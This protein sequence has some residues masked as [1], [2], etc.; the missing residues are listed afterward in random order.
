[1]ARLF[2]FAVL[3]VVVV[4]KDAT[5]NFE[6]ST[7]KSCAITFD[8]TLSTDCTMGAGFA[9][10]SLRNDFNTLRSDVDQIKARVDKLEDRVAVRDSCNDYPA[11]SSDGKYTINAA[12]PFEVDCVF[13][14]G[15]GW[16]A[17][18]FK[19]TQGSYKGQDW[20]VAGGYHADN[21]WWKCKDDMGKAYSFISDS[22]KGG[23]TGGDKIAAK[24]VKSFDAL[25]KFGTHNSNTKERTKLQ[26][27]QPSTGKTYTDAQMDHLRKHTNRIDDSTPMV[28]IDADADN[29]NAQKGTYGHEAAIFARDGSKF[30]CTPC[31]GGE[32]GGGCSGDNNCGNMHNGQTG[33]TY[34]W[35]SSKS[36]QK[37]GDHQVKDCTGYTGPLTGAYAKYIL[38]DKAE[39]H[40][41]TGGGAAFGYST[42]VFLTSS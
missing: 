25:S 10:N 5:L 29:S 35:Y 32:C 19:A 40:V 7:G 34:R 31:R 33:A 14:G 1:M 38:P 27:Y 26:Y 24:H 2:G 42:K 4:S 8:G 9:D 16:T 20:I 37:A 22:D 12:S 17:L 23:S 39:I 36:M 41:N 28:C 13:K 18:S 11:S 21:P 15:R 30:F 3:A 6:T